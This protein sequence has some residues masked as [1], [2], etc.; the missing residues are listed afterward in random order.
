MPKNPHDLEVMFPI[1]DE[2]SAHLMLVKALCLLQCGSI[3]IT[4]AA[5]VF[6]KA[7][8]AVYRPQ[9]ELRNTASH[10]PEA[11]IRIS[12]SLDRVVTS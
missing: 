5:A 6:R 12:S 1:N 9:P 8:E 11:A 4:E 2:P 10:A 3:E 7:S